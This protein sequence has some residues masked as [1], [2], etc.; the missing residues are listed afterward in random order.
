VLDGYVSGR[1][2]VINSKLS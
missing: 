1:T 2:K